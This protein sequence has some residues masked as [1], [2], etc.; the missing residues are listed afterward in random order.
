MFAPGL[1]KL[2]KILPKKEREEG[3]KERFLISVPLFTH[4]TEV[5]A[6]IYYT[7]QQS[8]DYLLCNDSTSKPN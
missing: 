4:Y 6:Y 1:H 8:L 7:I 2:S 5:R 3:G